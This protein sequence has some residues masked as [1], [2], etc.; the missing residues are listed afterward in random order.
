MTPGR[1]LSRRIRNTVRRSRR[2]AVAGVQVRPSARR[3]S[4]R[5]LSA[6]DQATAQTLF[7]VEAEGDAV[8]V[9]QLLAGRGC[10][11]SVR[12]VQRAV[13]PV[14]PPR[15]G[16]EPAERSGI[17]ATRA[18]CEP[19][20]GSILT[21]VPPSSIDRSAPRSMS[22]RCTSSALATV[23]T[24]SSESRSWAR[25]CTTLGEAPALAARIAEKSR[26]FVMRTNACSLA[27]VR[28]STSRALAAPI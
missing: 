22:S 4:T 1:R 15:V 13:A 12:T 3:L 26:S 19:L 16:R 25:I 23:L 21:R 24:A 17:A 14:R 18:P 20:R 5:R 2:G 8:V 9:K 28:I 7:Q 11:V 27:H 6:D 10:A